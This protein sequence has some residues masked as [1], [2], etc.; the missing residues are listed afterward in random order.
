MTAPP[1]RLSHPHRASGSV[2]TVSGP[3]HDVKEHVVN[4]ILNGELSPGDA[5][6][7]ERELATRLGVSRPLVREALRSLEAVNI[8]ESRRGA[9]TYVTDL[10]PEFLLAPLSYA[11]RLVRGS[12]IDLFEV[13]RF[14]EPQAAAMAALHLPEDDLSELD[15][16]LDEL[17]ASDQSTFP[18]LDIAFHE[19]IV[20]RTNN[21]LLL[22]VIRGI[23]DLEYQVLAVTATS[24][25]SRLLSGVEHRT[26]ASA[27]RA[28]DPER[29]K[30]AM[31]LHLARV[32]DQFRP[33]KA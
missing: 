32:E 3:L 13:R 23:R 25:E 5:L 1:P 9:G 22:S 20:R 17:D 33:G 21:R 19:W 24:A 6:P 28:R 4:L 7:A 27:I 16:L 31:L 11:F 18:E 2:K 10:S 29:A 26:I 8:V 15:Q 12:E 30:A 14:L